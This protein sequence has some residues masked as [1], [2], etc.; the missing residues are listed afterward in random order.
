MN[1]YQISSLGI[2]FAFIVVGFIWLGNYI[3]EQFNLS[4]W[5]LFGFSILGFSYG[6]YHIIQRSRQKM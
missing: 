4:P 1:L 3:D 6:L 5:G 2:E